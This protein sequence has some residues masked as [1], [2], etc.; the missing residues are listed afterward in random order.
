MGIKAMSLA[1]LMALT[2]PAL[3]FPVEPAMEQLERTHAGVLGLIPRTPD[4]ARRN[5]V[6]ASILS[7][8]Y[9]RIANSGFPA[10]GRY[11]I[12]NLP[13]FELQAWENG[14]LV[15]T[16]P[17]V[18]GRK[19][20]PTPLIVS[21]LTAL[22]LNPDW[23]VPPTLTD[24]Y[25][26]RLRRGNIRYFRNRGIVVR[27]PHGRVPFKQVD[28][29]NFRADGYRFW[30]P[31]GDRNS[32]GLLKFELDNREA[33]YL[34]DTNDPKLYAESR[35]DRSAGCIRVQ[36]YEDLAVW[37][38]GLSREEI[39]AGIATGRTRWKRVDPVPVHITYFTALPDG[40]GQVWFYPDIYGLDRV[41]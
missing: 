15:M 36:H 7:L 13:S 29:A 16:S 17:V 26:D 23:T 24:R 33:I 20:T 27:G 35:R 22:K 10:T 19:D 21:N 28:P 12:V 6:S 18:V 39:R 34:H 1:A 38:S 9:D 31:P 40:A 14:R 5:A 11:I 2:S 4:E 3:A 30:Q 25:L 37:V 32:L 41:S 8:N